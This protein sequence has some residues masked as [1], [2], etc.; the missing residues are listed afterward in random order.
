MPTYY[1]NPVDGLDTND[2]LGP[3]AA[4]STHR[5]FQTL[6]KIL[7]SGGVGVGGDVVY[8]APGVYR[9]LTSDFTVSISPASEIQ[10]IGDPKNTKGFKD[11]SGSLVK[12]APARITTWSD[13]KATVSSNGRFVLTSQS[14]LTFDSIWFQ[15]YTGQ[16]FSTSNPQFFTFRR[17][18]VQ[19]M[20]Y[21]LNFSLT[22]SISLTLDSCLFWNISNSPVNF[23]AA[24]SDVADWDVGITIKNCI[25]LNQSS[26]YALR[27]QKT[28]TKS[29]LPGG[30]VIENCTSFGYSGLAQTTSWST[31]LP[32]SVKNSNIMTGFNSALNASSIGEIVDAGGN[33][34]FGAG[35]L[36]NVTQHAS[37]VS[38]YSPN[39][40]ILQSLMWGLPAKPFSGPSGPDSSIIG[41]SVDSAIVADFL[42][43]IRPSGGGSVWN[44][45]IKTSGALELHDIGTKNTSDADGGSGTC[46]ELKG[47]GDHEFFLPVNDTATTLRV[48]VKYDSNYAGPDLPQVQIVADPLLGIAEQM[49]TATISA[50]NNYETILMD[51]IYPPSKSKVRVRFINRSTSGTGKAFFDTV[52]VS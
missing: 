3:N 35:T 46:L 33:T 11:A 2:G 52:T 34:Y 41:A 4:D 31:S 18:V 23:N 42:G 43:R 47:P 40:E 16:L 44:S 22:S 45:A 21:T 36:A 27:F 49:K 50:L 7:A 13:D 25:F 32:L 51:T 39:I 28:G 1:V 29:F 24:S 15:F 19:G 20:S 37:S 14:N 9:E 17:C 26:A 6:G 8:M 38:N 12:P 10:I 48:K 5:P 30:G